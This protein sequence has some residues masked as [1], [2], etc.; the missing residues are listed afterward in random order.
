M[1]WEANNFF[2]I[3][4]FC[5]LPEM[6]NKCYGQR[7]LT[8]LKGKKLILEIDPPNDEISIRRKG[9]YE[10]CG[11]RQNPYLHI[12]PPYHRED[13]GHRLVIMSSQRKLTAEEYSQFN[14]FL[15]NTVMKDAFI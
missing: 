15:Q 9:F 6:R 10:R 13:N 3:E 2:Y 8:L 1:Y 11:L 14:D 12:H 7:A 4:H 5:I